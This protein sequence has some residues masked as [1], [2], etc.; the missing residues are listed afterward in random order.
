MP[1]KVTAPER[2]T[3]DDIDLE[4]FTKIRLKLVE[5]SASTSLQYAALAAAI[6]V[7][8][9]TTI[10]YAG[11]AGDQSPLWLVEGAIGFIG[12]HIV[13]N[14]AYYG[15][16]SGLVGGVYVG[17]EAENGNALGIPKPTLKKDYLSRVNY[18]YVVETQKKAYIKR[19]GNV[20]AKKL[21]LFIIGGMLAGFLVGWYS[22][23]PGYLHSLGF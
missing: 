17:I 22:V 18:R 16:M 20:I 15:R 11:P 19:F 23:I 5:I 13:L 10:G 21:I 2:S 9:A 14:A 1:E 3:G 4:E 7:V 12:I 6:A 8:L